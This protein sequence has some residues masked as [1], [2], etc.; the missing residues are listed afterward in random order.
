MAPP[1]ANWCKNKKQVIGRYQGWVYEQS[2]V[3]ATHNNTTDDTSKGVQGG[4]ITTTTTFTTTVPE[5]A[6]IISKELSNANLSGEMLSLIN[7][8]CKVI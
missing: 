4:N 8:I 2:E 7:I 5:V 6:G 3:G 1:N